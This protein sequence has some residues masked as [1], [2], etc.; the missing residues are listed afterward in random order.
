MKIQ[1]V[2][3]ELKSKGC[4]RILVTGAHRAGTTFSGYVLSGELDILFYPE[5]NIRGG[6]LSLLQK[7]DR[8]HRKYVL[9]APGF[10]DRCH[11]FDFDAVVF[12]NRNSSDVNEAM[13]ILSD[14]LIQA[15]YERTLAV[16][17]QKASNLNLPE[18]KLKAFMKVQMP[19][20]KNALILDYE[21]LEG[22]AKWIPD[23]QRQ[24]WHI[25]QI[26]NQ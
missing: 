1:K 7:F 24:D 22:H 23:E 15:Q 12:V 2:I 5:E 21:S 19:K 18:L 16:L 20:I 25:R 17:D 4:K 8:T 11:L 6:N 3:E 13:K 26:N 10:S 14:R 9:Q